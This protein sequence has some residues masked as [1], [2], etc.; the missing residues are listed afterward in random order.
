MAT[1]MPIVIPSSAR[2][3]GAAVNATMLQAIASIDFIAFIF[4]LP[5][6]PARRRQCEPSPC[7]D[8]AALSACLRAAR[9]FSQLTHQDEQ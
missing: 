2:A 8:Y 3:C 9:S 5:V 4:N 7:V 6:T 1:A